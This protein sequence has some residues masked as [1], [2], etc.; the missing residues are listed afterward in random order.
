MMCFSRFIILQSVVT[1]YLFVQKVVNCY[2]EEIKER[3]STGEIQ[4]ASTD[5]FEDALDAVLGNPIS[6][7]KI[8]ITLTKSAFFIRERLFWSKMEK[9]LNGV[10]LSKDDCNKLQVKLTEN[11][12]K[13]E[14]AF[15]LVNIIDRAE[16]QRKISYLINATRCLLENLID[17]ENY[18]RTCHI[19]T[20]TLEEDLA[21]L[22]EHI[23]ET[24]LSYEISI[25][26]LLTSGLMYQSVIDAN[27]DQKYSFTPLAQ[28]VDQY[29]ISSN[30]I[31]RYPDLGQLINRF[32]APQTKLPGI[33][34][35]KVVSD[36][37]H[38]D[39]YMN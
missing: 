15:R 17:R 24:D 11:G 16:T 12:Q 30:N 21:F 13:E 33:L 29:A 37:D 39:I 34:E 14:N 1:R 7:G 27:D 2:I 9:F 22:G 8:I 18:F 19:I 20:S 26:G 25:Q 32:S 31:D 4:E 35:G 38:I 6:V 36:K 5:L 3:I 28:I 23:F 10:C